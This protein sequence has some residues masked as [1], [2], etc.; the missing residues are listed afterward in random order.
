MKPVNKSICRRCVQ[1]HLEICRAKTSSGDEPDAPF[2][3]SLLRLIDSDD[4][5]YRCPVCILEHSHQDKVIP[6]F[7]KYR[8]E[9]LMVEQ[10][11]QK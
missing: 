7:C 6:D 11:C 10:P 2:F 1:A 9:H 4:E 5:I 3:R 8:L